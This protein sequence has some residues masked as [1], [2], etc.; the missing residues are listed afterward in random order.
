MVK[1][2]CPECDEEK[3][4]AELISVSPSERRYEF[5]CRDCG[6]EG[7]TQSI[8]HSRPRRTVGT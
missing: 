7:S 3:T 8:I 4:N 5:R 2:R 6:T 1:Q